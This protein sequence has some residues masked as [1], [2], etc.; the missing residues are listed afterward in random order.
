MHKEPTISGV[1][2]PQ[3]MATIILPPVLWH[4]NLD[5]LPVTMEP[6]EVEDLRMVGAISHTGHCHRSHCPRNALH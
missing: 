5:I 1:L 3:I 6:N 2:L 4:D